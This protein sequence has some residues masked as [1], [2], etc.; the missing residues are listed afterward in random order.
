MLSRSMRRVLF[1][2]ALFSG[3]IVAGS[4]FFRQGSFQ[5]KPEELNNLPNRS[6]QLISSNPLKEMSPSI[7]P[8]KGQ[9]ILFSSEESNDSPKKTTAVS[10]GST[11]SASTPSA[12]TPSASTPSDSTP[13]DKEKVTDQAFETRTIAFDS[14]MIPE[15]ELK[16]GQF[17]LL[18][19]D[20]RVILPTH[21]HIRA[22]ITSAD[23]LHSWTVPSLGIK[24]D[25]TPGRLNQVHIYIKREGVYYGQCS[26]ICGVNHGFMPIVIK[27]VSPE[28]YIQWAKRK[29]Q[30][31]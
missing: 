9:F 17:R 23:V 14:Y 19:V 28:E 22:L 16:P 31:S 24:V 4:Y 30:E 3:S 15:A 11:P 13:S 12:S 20:N 2:S 8:N 29:L 10:S 1:S 7:I 18:D 21:T 5:R 6:S 26:E 25:A 27:A